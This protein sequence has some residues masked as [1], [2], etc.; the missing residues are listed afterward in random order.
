L[1]PKTIPLFLYF[2][3]LNNYKTKYPTK[4]TNETKTLVRLACKRSPNT[5]NNTSQGCQQKKQFQAQKF[6]EDSLLV[7]K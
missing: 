7:P 5:K 6:N 3:L 4:F 1:G 2:K